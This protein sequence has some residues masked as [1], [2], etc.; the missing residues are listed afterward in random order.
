MPATVLAELGAN[1]ETP[2]ANGTTPALVAAVAGHN[3]V[4]IELATARPHLVNQTVLAPLQGGLA[5]TSLLRVTVMGGHLEAAKTLILH[6]APLTVDDCKQ[7]AGVPG[8]ARR[9]RADIQS[10]AADAL[11]EHR[12][13]DNFLHGCSAHEGIA[14]SKLGGLEFARELIGELVGIVVGVTL[15]RM[16]AVG[17]AIEGVQWEEHDEEWDEELAAQLAAADEGEVGR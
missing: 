13:F 9:L 12:A 14:L 17:P 15:A 11:A 16:R 1:L 6:G 8:E 2:D 10:W 7:H 4:L 5:V 3:E